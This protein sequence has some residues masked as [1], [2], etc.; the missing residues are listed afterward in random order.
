[1]SRM[2][3]TIKER[4]QNALARADEVELA[5]AEWIKQNPHMALLYA[6]AAHLECGCHNCEFKKLEEDN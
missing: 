3:H 1:M 6:R 4:V 2:K 5:A